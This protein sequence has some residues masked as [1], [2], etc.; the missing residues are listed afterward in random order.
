M[1]LLE[2]KT[3]DLWFRCVCQEDHADMAIQNL[4]VLLDPH[5]AFWVLV[6]LSYCMGVGERF[7]GLMTRDDWIPLVQ[8]AIF[9][10][11]PQ[12]GQSA[13]TL[14]EK[15]RFG[16]FWSFARLPMQEKLEMLGSIVSRLG[17]VNPQHVCSLCKFVFTCLQS[18]II[19]YSPITNE[20]F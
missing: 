20:F 7:L 12:G 9:F 16:S 6:H 8:P 18:I 14:A 2:I 4:T 17:S 1:F 11:S 19:Y 3:L 10:N 13:Y 5:Q 15:V